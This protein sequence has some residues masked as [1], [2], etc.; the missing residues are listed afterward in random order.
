M[1]FPSFFSNKHGVVKSDKF[2]LCGEK[3]VIFIQTVFYSSNSE[4]EFIFHYFKLV[5]Y[6]VLSGE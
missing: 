6:L 4:N 1:N 2:P 5:I 3:C